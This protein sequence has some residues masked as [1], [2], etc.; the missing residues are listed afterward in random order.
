M[1]TETSAACDVVGAAKTAMPSS[2]IIN[3]ADII[4]PVSFCHRPGLDDHFAARYVFS[5]RAEM[6]LSNFCCVPPIETE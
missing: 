5:S 6:N 3:I 1:P 4:I 2:P